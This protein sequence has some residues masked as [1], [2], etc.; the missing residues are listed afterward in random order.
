MSG[1]MGKKNLRWP[2]TDFWRDRKGRWH[3][4]IAEWFNK[5]DST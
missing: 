3:S 2:I 4:I 1:G 5:G